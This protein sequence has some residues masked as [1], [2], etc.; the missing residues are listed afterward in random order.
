MGSSGKGDLIDKILY[1]TYQ[2]LK[3]TNH[4]GFFDGRRE[5]MGTVQRERD[6]RFC[7]QAREE[8]IYF[9]GY[10]GRQRQIPPDPVIKG[11]K[12]SRKE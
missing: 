9:Q 3:D 11:E 12:Q 4:A 7:G 1:G 8:M 10:A 6:I 5:R 2:C